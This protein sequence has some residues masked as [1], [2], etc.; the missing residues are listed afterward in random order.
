MVAFL[1]QAV[2]TGTT[3]ATT[4]PYFFPCNGGEFLI[5]LV[6]DANE[7]STPTPTPS[8]WTIITGTPTGTGSGATGTAI[9][10]YYKFAAP[11]D[12]YSMTLGD[13]GD[14]QEGVILA[15]I[16]VDRTNPF[17]TAAVASFLTP[18]STS[19]VFP[20][21]TTANADSLVVSVASNVTDT[22]TAQGS[23]FAHAGLTGLGS[24]NVQ[25]TDGNGGGF[26]Y[27]Y[28]IKA[29]AGATGTGS[30]TLANSS[31]QGLL[32]LALRTDQATVATATKLAS[33]AVLGTAADAATVSKA[34]A[35][36]VVRDS[37]SDLVGTPGVT[38]TLDSGATS[39]VD[40]P[41]GNA[42]DT[43][44]V[45]CGNYPSGYASVVGSVNGAYTKD[46]GQFDSSNNSAEIW[47][48]T[49]VAAAG[50]TIT[51]TPTI[52]SGNYVSAVACRFSDI[53][54]VS[55]LDKTGTANDTK[56]VNASGA[57]VQAHTLSLI[58]AVA[59]TG[60]S[61]MGF[62]VP[63]GYNL[64]ALE[65]AS[66]T[67]TGFLA[68]YKYHTAIQ[69]SGG[70]LTAASTQVDQ[71]I[72]TYKVAPPVISGSSATTIPVTGAA[73]GTL[74]VAGD[75]ATTISVTTE[76]AGELSSSGVS[77][78]S[79]TTV[80]VTTTA[81]GTLLIQ[82]EPSTEI[83]VTVEGTGALAAQ[84]ESATIIPVTTEAAG[85]LP[86]AGT[87]DTTIPVTTVAVG[88]LP[89]TA[90]SDTVIDI[91][92]VATGSASNQG[93]SATE[94]PI[95]TEAV[96]ILPTQG[97]SATEIPV[98]TE[99]TGTLSTTGVVDI[100]IPV[101]TSA[102]GVLLI[103]GES[104][105]T[106]DIA[107]TATGSSQAHG[108]VAITIPVTTEATGVSPI[109]GQSATTIPV[110]T[111]ATGVLPLAGESSTTIPIAAS[112]VGAL[113]IRGEVDTTIQ[114]TTVAAGGRHT[115]G[116]MATTI[117]IVTVAVGILREGWPVAAVVTG[118]PGDTATLRPEDTH[119]SRPKDTTAGRPGDR[120]ASRPT[121]TFG[122]R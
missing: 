80:D 103:Q 54:R 98:T 15:F 46:I 26:S 33:Y 43:A 99:S 79:A 17:D 5:C 21:I 50:E 73:T 27:L 105:T 20:A 16:G 118:R 63:V 76:A 121:D 29:T 24:G 83:P 10:G 57:N 106:I 115:A 4:Y 82:G 88:I 11:G 41:A 114:V 113:A 48:C 19:V 22:T 90:V 89:I 52:S 70:V 122:S 35:Y 71:V 119:V 92:T 30:C 117:D 42:G 6:E 84:G 18:G 44:Y 101:M 111:S 12:T 78:E 72:A 55:P 65:N 96:G 28:G 81:T 68:C 61:N 45:L 9:R 85:L 64:L 2:A 53:L 86:L 100:T 104:A 60:L 62:A 116:E 94:I 97:Q 58:F 36:A 67:Y 93:Q 77:G 87:V 39:T 14:H 74:A 13:L 69:T 47:R 8:G 37:F 40:L 110:T 112:A 7:G 107:T 56:T 1:G 31:V 75:A 25:G 102:A 38:K 59:D 95:T 109:L 32:T 51:L 108:Q 66:D 23:S 120:F 49:N 3:G 91:T 34:V